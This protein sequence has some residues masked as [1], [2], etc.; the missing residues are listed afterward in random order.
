[1][2]RTRLSKVPGI[3]HPYLNV[4]RIE[5][6]TNTNVIPGKVVLKLDRRMIPEED[7]T[8]V[9]ADVRRVI[10]EAASAFPGI[11]VEIRRLLLA[12]SWKPQSGNAPLV[13]AL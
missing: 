12:E 8:Q 11:R 3:H 5:G 6:G 7:P 1:M 10:A 2:L 9:E 13:Q 4:G